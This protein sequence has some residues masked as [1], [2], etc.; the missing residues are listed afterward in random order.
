M[1]GAFEDEYTERRRM[2]TTFHCLCFVQLRYVFMHGRIVDYITVRYQPC[3][4]TRYNTLTVAVEDRIVGNSLNIFDSDEKIPPS[5]L[6]ST[7]VMRM[8]G[9][10]LTFFV[11]KIWSESTE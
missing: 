2:C 8:F 10:F 9:N 4:I 3:T 11:L 6:H 7:F 1:R 5:S